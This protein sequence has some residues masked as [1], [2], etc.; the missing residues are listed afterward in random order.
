[1]AQTGSHTVAGY[2]FSIELFFSS[3]FNGLLKNF[4]LTTKIEN[5]LLS[6]MTS[7][8][9]R[10]KN[11]H[12]MHLEYFLTLVST[13][14]SNKKAFTYGFLRCIQCIRM[15]TKGLCDWLVLRVALDRVWICLNNFV[16]QFWAVHYI[17]KVSCLIKKWTLTMITMITMITKEI[18][19]PFTTLARGTQQPFPPKSVENL[20]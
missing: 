7:I 2:F 4:V 12:K 9:L 6:T 16:K 3:I 15:W 18:S 14:Q 13:G 19:N 1:M 10:N 17:F 11:L 20:F 5:A 8:Q